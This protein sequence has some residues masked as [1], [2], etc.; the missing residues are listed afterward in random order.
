[1]TD[2][3]DGSLEDPSRVCFIDGVVGFSW[4]S[5]EF[6]PAPFNTI[7]IVGDEA[8]P[9]GSLGTLELLLFIVVSVGLQ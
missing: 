1:M 8:A 2:V 7:S 6:R 3:G 5:N 9:R 4:G